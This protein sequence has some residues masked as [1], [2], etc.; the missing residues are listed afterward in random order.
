MNE[1]ITTDADAIYESILQSLEKQVEEPLYP[2]DERRIFAEALAFWTISMFNALNDAAKQKLLRYA[3]S[4]VLDALGERVGVTRI[5]ESAAKTQLRFSTSETVEE[6]IIIPQGTRVTNDSTHYFATVDLAVIEAGQTSVE[7][8]AESVG[9]GTSFNGYAPGTLTT[10]VDPII[11]VDSVTNITETSGGDDKES[12]AAYRERIRTAP[13]KLST[14]GPINGYKYYA[15]SAD[16][17]ISD[18]VVKSE[19]ETETAELTV[20]GRKAFMGGDTLLLGTLLVQTQDGAPAASETDYTA[21]YENGLLTITITPGGALNDAATVKVSIDRTNAGI[22]KIFPLCYGGKIPEEAILKK[23]Q[24]ACNASE[25]RP[26][27]D[28]VK[29]I[30]PSEEDYDIE[31]TYYTT[32]SDAGACT[33]TVESEGGAIDQY[34]AWQCEKLGRHIN[35]DKLRALILAP[36]ES[37][38]V[39]AARV[40]ITKPVFKELGETT[41]AHFSGSKTIKREV[42][43]R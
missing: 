34:I 4:D 20:Y 42:T 6:N 28:L 27:T 8:D 15:M 23:V 16:S 38:A 22:V 41:I 13:S 43:E 3:R 30:A 10:I 36:S 18:V 37:G 29:V 9:G 7:V 14:A 40:V 31:L 1:F 24:D 35:P 21:E 2:G 5:G 17:S 33:Q 25:V 12:D 32:A 11:Y 26:L 19:Q 39:G